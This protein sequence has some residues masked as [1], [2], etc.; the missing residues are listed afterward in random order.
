MKR[1]D[2][3]HLGVVG[4]CVAQFVA[5][6]CAAGPKGTVV[7]KDDVILIHPGTKL[8]EADRKD[9]NDTLSSYDKSLYKIETYKGGRLTRTMGQ[10]SDV[11][12]DQALVSEAA[13]AAAKGE[14]SRTLQVIAATMSQRLV[15]TTTNPQQTPG[16]TTNPQTTPGTTTNP[17]QT[18]GGT[19][20]PQRVPSGTIPP[21]PSPGATTNPQ[22]HNPPAIGEKAARELIER[23]KPILEKY[24]KQ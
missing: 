11:L 3:P 13:D 12:V 16:T 9:L 24:S 18:P 6:C 22:Q 23:L 4:F 20:N 15:G 5:L 10:L 21:G 8:T 17:Q 1:F 14:S 7:I 2:R 19:T